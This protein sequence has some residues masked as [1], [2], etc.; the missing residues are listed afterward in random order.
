MGY[1]V[2]TNKGNVYYACISR[3]YA[4]DYT[5]HHLCALALG[6]DE[7]SITKVKRINDSRSPYPTW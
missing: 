2:Y 4:E 3:Y 1:N 6:I 7:S 5:I